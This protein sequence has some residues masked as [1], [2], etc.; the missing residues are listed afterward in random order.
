MTKSHIF[1]TSPLIALAF[2]VGCQQPSNDDIDD[3]ALVAGTELRDSDGVA[4]RKDSKDS[5][6]DDSSDDASRDDE[7]SDDSD[8]SGQG[9]SD[10]DHK[11]DVC[12]NGM[13]LN[14][15]E[16]ALQAHLNHGDSEGECDEDTGVVVDPDDQDGDGWSAEED[17][18]DQDAEV[19]P[20]MTEVVYDGLDNDCNAD[21]PDDDLDGDGAGVEADCDDHDPQKGPAQAE[22]AYDGIDNDCDPGTPDDDL[23]GDGWGHA[24][25]CD[26]ED[27]AVNPDADDVCDGVDND[28][29]G[30]IDEDGD[31]A[32]AD[33]ICDALDSDICGDLD[34]TGGEACDDGNTLDG[35]G[36][37]SSCQVEPGSECVDADF[38][39][40]FDEVWPH[41]FH[42]SD[43]NWTVSSDNLTVQ[44]TLNSDAGVYMT[45]L[46][47]TGAT[48]AFEMAVETSSDDDFIGWVIGFKEG[49]SDSDDAWW[50]LF[51]WKQADQSHSTLG[52]AEAGLRLSQ[53]RGAILNHSE[54]WDHE[55]AVTEL[56]RAKTLGDEGWQDNGINNV[57]LTYSVDHLLVVVNGMVE[58]DLTPADVGLER[59]PEG[60]F[61]FYTFSQPSDRFTLVSP[62]SGSICAPIPEDC[63]G[64]DNDAD[65]A[66]DEGFDADGDGFTSC[67][68][69]CDDGDAGVNPGADELCDGIDNDCDGEID[70]DAADA[71]TWYLDADGD[72]HGDAGAPLAVCDAPEGYVESSDDCDDTDA[73]VSPSA[74]EVVYDGLD[75]DCDVDTPDDDLDGDGWGIADDCDDADAAVNPGAEEIP[76]DGID[77]DCAPETADDDLDG[78][79]VGL[80]D[81][82]DDADAAVSPE[83]AEIVYDGVD[84]DCDPV[85]PDDDLDGD[86]AGVSEDCDDADASVSPTLAEVAYDGI[87]NDCDPATPDDDIDQDGWN[88][89]DDCDDSDAAVHPGAE[90]INGDGIDNNCDGGVD[91]VELTVWYADA[92]GDG[93]GDADSPVESP[94]QPP[95]FVRS[96]DDCDDA[97]A[98][99]NPLATEICDGIDNDCDGRIDVTDGQITGTVALSALPAQLVGN[100]AGDMIGISMDVAGDFDGDGL[101]ELVLG[102]IGESTRGEQAGAAFLIDPMPRGENHVENAVAKVMGQKAGDLA[103]SAVAGIGD[104]TGDGVPDIAVGAPGHNTDDGTRD[105]TEGALYFVSGTSTG[106][107][108]LAGSYAK[109]IAEDHG[110]FVGAAVDSAGDVNGD[111]HPDVIIGAVGSE[112]T[113]DY[114]GG[115]YV[116]SQQLSGTHAIRDVAARISGGAEGDYLGASVG[117]VGDLNGDGY[118]DVAVGAFGRDDGGTEGGALYVFYGPIDSDRDISQ[119]DAVVIGGPGEL[120]GFSVSHAGDLNGD[121]LDDLLLGAPS[122]GGA[123]AAYVFYGPV[124]GQLDTSMADAVLLGENLGDEAG[125]AVAGVGDMNGDGVGDVLV[126]APGFDSAIGGELAGAAYIVFG[127][128]AGELPLA[129][130]DVRLI[131]EIAGDAA[132]ISVNS[133]GDFDGDGLADAMVG[134]VGYNPY[135]QLKG[136]AYLIPGALLTGQR[137]G[138]PAYAD[139]DGDGWGDPNSPLQ[140]CAPSDGYVPTAGDCDDADPWIH[141]GAPEVCDDGIDNDCDSWID[142]MCDHDPGEC[143]CI[144][145]GTC[146]HTHEDDTD[147]DDASDTGDASGEDTGDESEDTGAVSED[148]G[149]A[150]EDTNVEDESEDTGVASGDTGVEDDE[151][152]TDVD[153]GS[154]DG[155]SSDGGSSDGGSSDGGEQDNDE[156]SDTGVGGSSDGG[157]ADGGSSDGGSAGGGSSDDGDEGGSD[158]PTHGGPGVG[159]HDPDCEYPDGGECDCDHGGTAVDTGDTGMDDV[160]SGLDT[161][162]GMADADTAAGED[163]GA[164]GGDDTGATGGDDTG[165]TGDDTGATG[166]DE[167]ELCDGID[168]DGDGEIDESDAIDALVWYADS[169]GDGYGDPDAAVIACE[170]PEGFVADD[171][172][173]DD[174]DEATNLMADEYCD[175]VDNNCDGL[176]DGEDSL[177]ALV[178]N[179]DADGDGYGSA[180]EIVFSCE[181]IDG[182]VMDDS[183]CD[184]SSDA[185]HPG[186]DETCDGVDN[187]CDGETDEDAI[188]PTIWYADAD[189]D[190][191]YPRGA[192][193]VEACEQPEGY[194]PQPELTPGWD[195]DDT[196][197][198]N[199]PGAAEVCDGADNDCDTRIDE[200]DAIDKATWYVDGDGD[201]WGDDALTFQSCD[202]PA[203]YVAEAGDCNDQD[204]AVAPGLDELCDGVDNNCDGAIDGDDA[205][206]RPSW[207]VDAD[208]DG[209]GSADQQ[210]LACEQ[211]D[212]ATSDASDCDDSDAAVSPAAE[213]IC[214]GIDNDCDGAIDDGAAGGDTWYADADG[215]SY[216]DA[217]SA[218]DF[219]DDPGEGWVSDA[220]DCDDTDA[221]TSPSG[222]EVCD[223]ADNDCDGEADEDA[224]DATTWYLDLD[225]DGYGDGSSSL[226]VCDAPEGYVANADDC[227]DS[228]AAVN[229]AAEEICDGLDNDCDGSADGSDASD[230]LTL[231]QDLD[232]DG[233]G[234][235]DVTSQACEASGMYVENADDC[236]D[237]SADVNPAAAEI[238][239]DVDNDCSGEID[240]G[241]EGL[242]SWY[243]DADGDLHGDPAVTLESCEQPEGYVSKS[244]DCDDTNADVY[245]D[246]AEAC[247]D[248]DNDCD[249]EI[250][251][252]DHRNFYLDADGDGTGDP[253]QLTTACKQPEGYIGN[254]RDCDDADPEVSGDL[255]EVCDGKDNNCDGN[256][257]EDGAVDAPT[258]YADVD[259]DAY[260]QKATALQACEQPDGYV[261]DK[262]DCDDNDAAIN[263]DAVEWCDDVDNDCDGDTDED[264]AAD[265]LTWFYDDDKDGY[266]DALT[267]A[268]ACSVPDGY[269]DNTDDCDDTNDAIYP[270]AIEWC[271]DGVDNDCDGIDQSC[272]LWGNVAMASADGG[273]YGSSSGHMVGTAVAGAGDVNGD[274]EED[275]VVGATD[276]TDGSTTSGAAYLVYGPVTGTLDAETDAVRL[277]G[278]A[279]GDDAGESVAGLGDVNGDGY[280]DIV[281]GA[282]RNDTLASSA[283]ASYVVY[284][285]I[286]A[287][288][289]LSAA[290]GVLLGED[291]YGRFGHSVQPVGDV[292]GDGSPD[293]MVSA[294]FESVNGTKDG[295]A[296][297]FTGALSGELSTSDAAARV[298]GAAS[299][300]YLGSDLST[301]GDVDGDGHDDIIIGAYLNDDGG[302]DAGAAY[303]LRGPISGEVSA[304]SADASLIGANPGDQA[305]TSVG[306][307]GDVN[308]DG[309]DDLLVGAPA[310]D[311]GGSSAGAVYVVFGPIDGELTLSSAD[312]MLTGERSGNKAGSDVMMSDYNRDG[313][314]D[315]TVGSPGASAL[316]VDDGAV[317]VLYGPFSG[318]IDLESADAVVAGETDNEKIGAYLGF[319]DITGDGYEDLMLG[320]PA[321]DTTGTSAG[322]AIILGGGPLSAS[323]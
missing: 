120:V 110:D 143:P 11:V 247:D 137:M 288:T 152:P 105:G 121:G 213:E 75:N 112:N 80:A 319:G 56:A 83:Q 212:G 77:N 135:G 153:T 305:G 163:T 182:A 38:S 211:P 265:A 70:N 150:D 279:N 219:C 139:L 68:D 2:L 27:A 200:I 258:W 218:Q 14:I 63:D 226:A 69:D 48:I 276:W 66:I 229:P 79:G 36:C 55:G 174:A 3:G 245:P 264:D 5:K 298:V 224:A 300:D 13:T 15:A 104:V 296:H 232:G 310:N 185:D 228:D 146:D 221:A 124:T 19:N 108:G 250:D 46:P 202:A 29:D 167:V 191:Y 100:Q 51:D 9:D 198:D 158:C 30:D 261:S 54:L 274:G 294:W 322:A 286:S 299:K 151:T 263:P 156:A 201:G 31:D 133:A 169:D 238:C 317:H 98:A 125:T 321:N 1:F 81:D 18:D 209:Y 7:S 88:L 186:A 111:G 273:L 194:T 123:G 255:D 22:I 308:G 101:D 183:D 244:D 109:L 246:A 177:D 76:Y 180:D 199:H 243:A 249:G 287:T 65:G 303:L 271:G 323:E 179:V 275:M 206:D 164:A 193:T 58:F 127:P 256:I 239:D 240:D 78:D 320:V 304:S 72:H 154:S 33:G 57:E 242:G 214:D 126:G 99:V 208:G 131:G 37:D 297:L 236:D 295:A 204:A 67:N 316:G 248:L 115:A 91:D 307:G 262:Q 289:D 187:D 162:D 41:S 119:A 184:D 278:E 49:D 172:D 132:G 190:G 62:T 309:Y 159:E 21:T 203:G 168:N 4:A 122:V 34:I 268:L 292:D 8:S 277:T 142:P 113:G 237:G 97:N 222:Q 42:D 166:G 53:V 25:D 241:A 129:D 284:G 6:D 252:D 114:S 217:S 73:S 192:A 89:A 314:A 269:V 253:D 210:V 290:D 149:L 94:V 195:C 74:A 144:N 138:I 171:S 10:H 147:N 283:G 315:V 291:A 311:D 23:D 16:S 17:C 145:M 128:V 71:A 302:A 215:D 40:D 136:L 32:D 220:S 282:P 257:D 231:Y 155:G 118:D 306:G 251:E 270:D 106:N 64:T 313:Y 140:A 318:T 85:T 47:A 50:L 266:G 20:G 96:D 35:D 95:G 285:P 233:Y 293:L 254:K 189:G 178:W 281:V 175:G 43:P 160:D 61:G 93:H 188:D 134:T 176:V 205:V 157:S 82:C 272:G 197:A 225:G 24:S 301:A 60:N 235:P 312:A 117:G 59:F 130:A 165:P 170:A 92:D 216:G 207:N 280:D 259:G 52:N 39:V 267:T 148:T 28:C 223:G 102:A 84:N 26:D 161:G 107:I 103:G 181:P 230:T 44:Q 90:E 234:N 141:P 116:V 196:S 227:D 260:G 173:C 45:N 12:H 86:G 87:D